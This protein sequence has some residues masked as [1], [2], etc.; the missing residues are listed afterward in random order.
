MTV[1]S[2]DGNSYTVREGHTLTDQDHT[3]GSDITLRFRYDDPLAEQ[4][5]FSDWMTLDVA[6]TA[7]FLRPVGVE[8][9]TPSQQVFADRLY[10]KVFPPDRERL[11]TVARRPGGQVVTYSTTPFDE[12]VEKFKHKV[13]TDQSK[14][15]WEVTEVEVVRRVSVRRSVE[16]TEG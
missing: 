13:L 16:V 6:L 1:V 12:V 4:S 5:G 3:A 14:V 9:L 2:I 15:E 10:E 7:G 11:V 8:G